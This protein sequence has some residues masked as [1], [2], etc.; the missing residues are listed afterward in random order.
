MSKFYLFI[1]YCYGNITFSLQRVN[2]ALF[3][4]TAGSVTI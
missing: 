3:P 1:L 2:S 4:L